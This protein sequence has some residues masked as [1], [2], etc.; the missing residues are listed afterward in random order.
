[1][2]RAL[3]AN[4]KIAKDSKETVQEC[5]SEFISFIT[6]ECVF[7][8]SQPP[9]QPHSLTTCCRASDKCLREKRKTINGDDL[10]WA[11]STLGFEEY[12]DPLRCG[13]QAEQTCHVSRA[14]RR[15]KASAAHAL[16]RVY[17]QNHRDS[18]KKK[19]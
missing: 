19:G 2:K 16:R 5:V 8:S 6:S 7:W 4:A 3:P 18:E 17:L 12:V 15:H 9:Q 13:K 11:L 14:R 1:M 10:L